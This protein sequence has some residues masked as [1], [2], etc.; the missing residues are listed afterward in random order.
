MVEYLKSMR[1]MIRTQREVLLKFLG[2]ESSEINA[3]IGST[4]T[5]RQADMRPAPP[6]EEPPAVEQDLT[7]DQVLL[8][9][10]S[11]RTGY[12]IDMLDLDLD[13]AADLSIDSIKRIEILGELSKRMGFATQDTKQRDELVEELA[14]QKT[15]RN[16]LDWLQ[17]HQDSDENESEFGNQPDQ[18]KEV[19]HAPNQQ[20]SN[21]VRRY[22]LSVEP[23]PQIV[24][25]GV[26]LREKNFVITPADS[27]LAQALKGNLQQSGATVQLIGKNETCPQNTDGLICLPDA[28]DSSPSDEIERLFSLVQEAL[29]GGVRWVLATTEM[30]GKFAQ[31]LKRSKAWLPGGI[32]GLLKTAAQ[33]WPQAKIKVVDVDPE[34][35]PEILARELCQELLADDG[36]VEVGYQKGERYVCKPVQAEIGNQLD[37][38]SLELDS[39]SVILITGGG[40]G[41]T[42]QVARSLAVTYACKMILV[43][44]SKLSQ[45]EEL[46]DL[47]ECSDLPQLRRKLVEL[48][49]NMPPAQ[50]DAQ[51]RKI[52]AEREIRATIAA[53][54]QAGGY[55]EYNSIDVSDAEIF[56]NFIDDLYARFG[57]IDGVIHGAG[58]V[59]D[60]LIRHKTVDSFKHVF[61]TKV[62]GALT[63]AKKIRKDVSFVV[64]FSSIS[65]VFGNRGQVDYSAAN[66]AM[67]QLAWSLNQQ[68]AG[69]VISIN[70]GP[71][72]SAGTG[73]VSAELEREYKNRG[74]GVI[75][76]AEGITNLLA[77]LNHPGEEAQVILMSAAPNNFHVVN[78]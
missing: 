44:R 36:I 26:N 72:S 13:L 1:E 31:K 74:I 42:S 45:Q 61:D 40:R 34:E 23:A 57:R 77:E 25:N 41:I 60:K 65:S 7:I 52:I 32:S 30:G 18:T 53:V 69:R 39:S 62:I 76:L 3:E 43:G 49:S 73:M 56:A 10:I 54:R 2:T 58:I 19:I 24:T 8:E 51:A 37:M 35:N 63:L 5:D 22:V 68:L 14:A 59:E 70:W 4:I 20:T 9:I 48:N 6:K 12:P 78:R 21:Q 28:T 75:P 46:K 50:I 55:V 33:E 64:F 66:H 15:I 71:W 17:K 29:I 27:L 16:I 67:D 38:A 11:D 47:V